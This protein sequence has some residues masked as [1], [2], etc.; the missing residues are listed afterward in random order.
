MKTSMH[1]RT[2]LLGFSRLSKKKL[3]CNIQY[4]F[5]A[6]DAF[7]PLC[8]DLFIYQQLKSLYINEDLH[9]TG[10]NSRFFSFNIGTIIAIHSK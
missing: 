5:V 3:H 6:F 1:L 10:E 7:F 8:T 4:A 9:F 2:Y